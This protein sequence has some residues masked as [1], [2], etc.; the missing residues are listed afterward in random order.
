MQFISAKLVFGKILRQ[1]AASALL[2]NF[3][4]GLAQ[5]D[6]QAPQLPERERHR[7]CPIVFPAIDRYQ[8]HTELGGKL[9]LC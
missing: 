7:F 8:G 1:Q 9:L 3:L 4:L 2:S 5:F 6:Q